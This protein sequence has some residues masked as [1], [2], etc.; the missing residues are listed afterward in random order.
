[1]LTISSYGQ[2]TVE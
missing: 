2:F 1:V